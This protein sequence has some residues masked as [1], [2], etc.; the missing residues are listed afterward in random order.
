MSTAFHAHDLDPLGYYAALGVAPDA[1][2][3]EIQRAYRREAKRWHPDRSSAPEAARR[4]A[5]INEAFA[6]LGDA[7]KRDAYDRGGGGSASRDPQ[8]P[9][10]VVS[11]AHVDFG[12]LAPGER[13][14]RVALVANAGGPCATVRIEPEFGSWFRLAEARGGSSPDVLVEL[15][16]EAFLDPSLAMT[17]GRHTANVTV[18]LDDE[19]AETVLGMRSIPGT[20]RADGRV[21]GTSTPDPM[22]AAS[23]SPAARYVEARPVWQRVALAIVTGYLAPFFLVV[24]GR[25]VPDLIVA[26][27]TVAGVLVLL[28]A[29][30]AWGTRGFRCIATAS[31]AAQWG[32]AGVLVL[33][34]AFLIGSAV[35]IALMVVLAIAAVIV[36]CALVALLFAPFLA[37]SD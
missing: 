17:A 7:V 27:A 15:H 31:R 11:P 1:T 18:S 2:D 3:H 8:P 25:E 4:M 14:T 26:C 34:K 37:A 29:A 23:A 10:P 32:A 6:V 16:F 22:P 36:A 5:A 24:L 12:S 28:T 9:R 21:D 30:A 19:C 33:G 20:V 13:T 35:A